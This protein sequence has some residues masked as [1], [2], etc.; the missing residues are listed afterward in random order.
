VA[1]PLKRLFESPDADPVE[2]LRAVGT[3]QRYLTAVEGRAVKAAR[4]MGRS[5][6]DIGQ[7]LGIS[8]QAAWERFGPRVGR[9][10]AAAARAG[11]GPPFRIRLQCTCP[12]GQILE[13]DRYRDQWFA[14]PLGT[15]MLHEVPGPVPWTCA[16]CGAA[17]ESWV[18]L[19]PDLPRTG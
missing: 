1:D 12:G 3:Y 11:L 10:P 18:E 6:E 5:W 4:A 14:R 8:R 15:E 9:S 13:L 2:V 17:H 7:A 19:P 16:S